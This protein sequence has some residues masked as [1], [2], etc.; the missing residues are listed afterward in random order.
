MT[1]VSRSSIP[2]C[3]DV[4]G[5]AYVS[6]FALS[7]GDRLYGL[8]ASLRNV[9]AYLPPPT[10]G[11]RLTF[12]R[13]DDGSSECLARVSAKTT[14]KINGSATE[15]IDLALAGHAMEF[16]ASPDLTTWRTANHATDILR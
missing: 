1:T 16:V 9:R 11:T 15:Y 14:A 10:A 7:G 12:F 8:D 2:V 3:I 6:L 4:V 13:V 5:Q